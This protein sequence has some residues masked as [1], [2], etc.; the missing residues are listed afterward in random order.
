MSSSNVQVVGRLTSPVTT[1]SPARS[2]DS[3]DGAGFEATLQ[4]KVLSAVQSA[5]G[6]GTEAAAIV[7]A[8]AVAPAAAVP[9]AGSLAVNQPCADSCPGDGP[10]S[11]SWH[12]S[13]FAR[14][15]GDLSGWGKPVQAQFYRAGQAV[16][17]TFLNQGGW[18]GDPVGLF[19]EGAD[20]AVQTGLSGSSSFFQSI[21]DQAA[22][23]FDPLADTLL[24]SSSLAGLGSSSAAGI[25]GSG[26]FDLARLRVSALT[27]TRQPLPLANTSTVRTFAQA[28][29]LSS[30]YGR[31]F[32][33]DGY[34]GAARATAAGTTTDSTS[35][36]ST[37]AG[38]TETGMV[39][40]SARLT[41]SGGD[42]QPSEAALDFLKRFLGLVSSFL[43]DLG[44]ES[45][46]TATSDQAA[47]ATPTTPATTAIT[48]S[49]T[50]ATGTAATTDGT[51]PGTDAPT[52]GGSP[53]T[54]I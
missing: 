8:A 24:G 30:P 40:V 26:S 36:G 17:E 50:D 49:P 2:P 19:L 13:F 38:N 35:T 25:P 9:A 16:A 32:P 15:S 12:F 53:V 47:P 31:V 45:A 46:T 52:D 34:P 27:Q 41:V 48:G 21:R 1:G 10:V 44:G 20:R 18:Q 42:S 29:A 3:V 23:G 22:A 4:N 5:G 11:Y 28:S 37:G 33:L 54:V 6:A 14:V 7:S 51:E 43:D 39:R